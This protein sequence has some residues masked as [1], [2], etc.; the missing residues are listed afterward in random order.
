[1]RA[2]ICRAY[3]PPEALEFG[4]LPA[5]AAGEGQVL[6]R[7]RAAGVN[8]PDNLIIQGRYQLKPA[9]PFA[10]GFEV[11]GEVVAVGAGV[12]KFKVGDRIMGLSAAGYGAFAELAVTDA[13]TSM[14][15]PDDMDDVA[16]TAFF[17][18]YGTSY[19]ALV[20]R[21]RLTAG[22]TLLVLGA[23]GGVGLAAIE[24]GKA[25]GA[26]VIAVASS[27][28]KLDVA[29]AHGADELIDY[30]AQ[31]LHQCVRQLTA[32]AGVDVCL[33]TVGGDA[34][35]TM[36]RNMN[37]DGRLLVVGFASG[38]IPQ[39][40][41]NLPLLK[42]YQVV[43]VWWGPFAQR[44]PESNVANF[45][46]LFAMYAAGKLHP[47]VFRT[48]PLERCREALKELLGRG[49]VGRLVLIV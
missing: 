30:H 20:Q 3:G 7:V 45:G 12:A 23:S 22:E 5:P 41:V 49:V 42:G 6:V 38:R 39:L 28:E 4:E 17:A 19:H 34:F 32:G 43:G 24:I 9:M 40:P 14:P 36:S 48:Y 15:I 21:G 26:R 1:M 11:A 35:D 10:P 46:E 29:R 33:D 8:F 13:S 47:R 37:W 2:I 27:P 25:L 16:A 44:D 18:P 31:D